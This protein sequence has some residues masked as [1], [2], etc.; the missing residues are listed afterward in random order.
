L[1]AARASAGTAPSLLRPLLVPPR[2]HSSVK[3]IFG[4][5]AD[6]AKLFSS[7]RV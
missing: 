7:W 2:G 1:I 5:L 3:S 4:I 6:L